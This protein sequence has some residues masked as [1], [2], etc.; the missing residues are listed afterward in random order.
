MSLQPSAF[1]SRSRRARRGF[2]LIELVV[3]VLIIGITAA[4]ATPTLTSQ[5]R[6][7]R[8]RDTAQQIA[9]LYSNARMRALGRGAAVLVRYVPGASTTPAVFRVYESRE[10]EEVAKNS[11]GETSTCADRPGLGCLTNDWG[12]TT[13]AGPT[14]EVTTL[15]ALPEIEVVAGGAAAGATRLDICFTPMGRSFRRN[16]AGVV[17]AANVNVSTFTVTRSTTNGGQGI[18]R[19]VVLLPNGMARLGL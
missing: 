18:P 2:T 1:R 3:V 16:T 6:E 7:R 13:A 15:T 17:L 5:F 12:D 9:L 11:P 10:G 14:R 19:V 8:A 4:L